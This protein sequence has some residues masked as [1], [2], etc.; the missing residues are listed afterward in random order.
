MD[1]FWNW[2]QEKTG[3]N[4]FLWQNH[5]RENWRDN[6]IGHMMEFCII[7]FIEFELSYAVTDSILSST[8]ELSKI[9][10]E[11]EQLIN[12]YEE[13]TENEC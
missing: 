3:F 4:E 6:L 2:F 12:N 11:L 10:S 7:H 5:N 8:E 9:Y 13:S 1:K